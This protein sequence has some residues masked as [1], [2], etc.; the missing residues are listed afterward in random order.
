MT[1]PLRRLNKKKQRDQAA[2]DGKEARSRKTKLLRLLSE[3]QET[4]QTPFHRILNNEQ[5]TQVCWEIYVPLPPPSKKPKEGFSTPLERLQTEVLLQSVAFSY[6]PDAEIEIQKQW[7]PLVDSR[8]VR[9][10]VVAEIIKRLPTLKPECPKFGES[11]EFWEPILTSDTLRTQNIPHLFCALGTP[12]R[13]HLSLLINY[14]DELVGETILS[15]IRK[16]AELG[17]LLDPK[18]H[19]LLSQLAQTF[20]FNT[21][22][23]IAKEPNLSWRVLP[24]L[25]DRGLPLHSR[26]A[27]DRIEWPLFKRKASAEQVDSVQKY[28]NRLRAI[29]TDLMHRYHHLT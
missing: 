5:L 18:T 20:P 23:S 15:E 19:E 7:H 14:P 10:Q 26:D 22:I 1:N 17:T 21:R 12:T 8:G 11:R 29:S 4:R 2:P 3:L 9:H 6:Q 25:L 24:R 27:L 13:E 16:I 28:L